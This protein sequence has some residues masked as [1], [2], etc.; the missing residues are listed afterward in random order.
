MNKSK[1]V[2]KQAL[3][4][5]GR[6]N[7]MWCSEWHGHFKSHPFRLFTL[8]YNAIFC[9]HR[10]VSFT[11][12]LHFSIYYGMGKVCGVVK[13]VVSLDCDISLSHIGREWECNAV[14]AAH[15]V[16]HNSIIAFGYSEINTC[17]AS[18]PT[19]YAIRKWL[20]PS[21][22]ASKMTLI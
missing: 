13:C 11:S 15:Y 10:N 4:R 12:G 8:S 9:L 14:R 2:N 20:T 5:H 6:Y 3:T 17:L 19:V 21:A 7:Q 1:I 18:T 16:R 22:M